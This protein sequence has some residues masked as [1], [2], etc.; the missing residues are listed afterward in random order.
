MT[1]TSRR[2]RRRRRGHVLSLDP[3]TP[4][5]EPVETRSVGGFG[6]G[7]LAGL[8]VLVV[9]LATAPGAWGAVTGNIP[10]SDEGGV[11]VVVTIAPQ[12][13]EE[14]PSS[15]GH[16]TSTPT[17]TGVPSTPATPQE[18]GTSEPTAEPSSPTAEPSPAGTPEPSPSAQPDP[19][20]GSNASWWLPLLLLLALLAASLLWWWRSGSAKRPRN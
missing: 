1:A 12:P 17:A 19:G 4:L 11:G 9:A 15:P 10:R 14:E 3:L 5:A 18:P 2:G 8:A 6:R 7:V 16:P 20:D 13:D